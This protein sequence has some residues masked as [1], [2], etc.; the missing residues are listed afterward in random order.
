MTYRICLFN[1]QRI[2]WLLFDWFVKLL[3]DDLIG[4]H[5][6]EYVFEKSVLYW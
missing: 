6:I 5:L 4:F 1:Q 3:V 2:S